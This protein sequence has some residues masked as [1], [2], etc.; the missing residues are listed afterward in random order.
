MGDVIQNVF[1]CNGVLWIVE[2]MKCGIV[3]CI[4][5][6][7]K[8]IDGNVIEKISIV[9]VIE[10]VGGYW[11]GKIGGKFCFGNYVNFSSVYFVLI[12]EFYCV[13][14]GKIVMFVGNYYVIVMVWVQFYW[15][16]YFLG[17]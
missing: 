7:V 9:K 12:I 1:D 17:S 14:V 8:C 4:G 15:V 10:C 13:V 6:V 16:F 3:L 2:F 5:F 11:F